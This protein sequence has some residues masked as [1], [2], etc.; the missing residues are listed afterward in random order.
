M[1]LEDIFTFKNI[2]EAH[3]K[4]RKSKQHK[5]EVIRFEVNLSENIY[6][7]R[8]LLRVEGAFYRVESENKE[9]NGQE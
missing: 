2:Y 4:C 8:P 5:G 6:K 9:E 3:K 1:K 7:T